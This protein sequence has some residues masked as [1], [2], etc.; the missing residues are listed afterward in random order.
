MER[1][2]APKIGVCRRRVPK[3]GHKMARRERLR[4]LYRLE[5][6]LRGVRWHAPRIQLASGARQQP[7]N[8]AARVSQ[9]RYLP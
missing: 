5:T 9:R 4:I 8:G 3:S 1:P 6:E 2:G 7:G